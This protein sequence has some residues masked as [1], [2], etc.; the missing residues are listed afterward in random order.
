M[1]GCRPADSEVAARRKSSTPSLTS[2]QCMNALD[3]HNGFERRT[4][5]GI[6]LIRSEG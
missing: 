5:I 6:L 3:V 1:A 4:L 2:C